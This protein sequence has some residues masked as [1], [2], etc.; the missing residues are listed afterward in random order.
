M[1]KILAILFKLTEGLAPSLAG[2]LAAFLFFKP[3]NRR[4]PHRQQV[5]LNRAETQ[6]IP[7]RNLPY[8]HNPSGTYTLYRRGAGPA[9]LLVHG[10]GGNALQMAVL[11]D[12]LVQAGYE[13]ITFDAFAHGKSSGKRTNIMEFVAI[14]KDIEKRTG[15][16]QAIIA[17]SLGGMAAA[18]AVKKGVTIGKLITINAPASIDFIFNA[19][20][21]QINVSEKS[22]QYVACL[23]ERITRTPIDEFSAQQ[24]MSD[25]QTPGLIIHDRHDKE[26]PVDQGRLLH[27]NWVNSR[28]KVTHLLGHRRILRDQ[29]TISNI[30]EYLNTRVKPQENGLPVAL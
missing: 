16:L 5:D 19:F 6:F 1:R 12:A 13:A 23:V 7:L 9:V 24:L 8:Y 27:E 21:A 26:V 3:L 28:L 22:M 17:H 15:G 20:A 10:W 29:K 14:I 11:V 18:M 4:P 2:K 25:I 30:I